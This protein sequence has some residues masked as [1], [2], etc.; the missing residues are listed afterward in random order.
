MS[1]NNDLNPTE[2]EARLERYRQNR[3]AI[4][5][6]NPVE[7][8]NDLTEDNQTAEHN[9]SRRASHS[10]RRISRGEAGVSSPISPS[11]NLTFKKIKQLK[12]LQADDVREYLH[13]FEAARDQD[14]LLS[15]YLKKTL[16]DDICADEPEVEKEIKFKRDNALKAYLQEIVDD[17]DGVSA[18]KDGY[19]YFKKH[20]K[21]SKIKARTVPNRINTYFRKAQKLKKYIPGADEDNLVKEKIYDLIR[22]DIDYRLGLTEQLVKEDEKYL[23]LKHLKKYC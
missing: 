17:D 8:Y 10:I 23:D 16:L 13:S 18:V 21:W 9:S 15:D 20:L 7:T 19:K 4:V 14:I 6:G 11:K 2:R 3:E 12:T 22:K 1:E 5:S